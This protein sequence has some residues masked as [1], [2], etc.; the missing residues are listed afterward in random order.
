MQITQKE[1]LKSHIGKQIKESLN[2][3][4]FLYEE[5]NDG[6]LYIKFRWN[7]G[8]DYPISNK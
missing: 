3:L 5:G 1:I 2:W 4:S 7:V 8:R 6:I